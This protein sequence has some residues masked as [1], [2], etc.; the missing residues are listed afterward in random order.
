MVAWRWLIIAGVLIGAALWLTN[1][2]RLRRYQAGAVLSIIVG[3]LL[4]FGLRGV[5][6]I[7][8]HA[9]LLLPL[10]GRELIWLVIFYGI[11][12]LLFLQFMPR[13]FKMLQVPYAIMSALGTA[14]LEQVIAGMHLFGTIGWGAFFLSLLVHSMR[15]L[16]LTGIF[17]AFDLGTRTGYSA[18]QADAPWR[19]HWARNMWA[20][21]WPSTAIVAWTFMKVTQR[22]AR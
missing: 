19:S 4:E 5:R 21:A 3:M 22:L 14:G 10:F 18:S 15:L 11:Q 8:D 6:P 2:Q 9:I 1:P 12:G 20:L 17:Y 13:R 7:W 16:A